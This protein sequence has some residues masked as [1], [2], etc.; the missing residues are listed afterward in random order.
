MADKVFNGRI[1]HKN[2]IEENWK[3]AIN[4]I[5]KKSELIIYNPD[6]THAQARVKVGD[7][8]TKV[9]DL[10]FTI[11][12]VK[13]VTTVNGKTGASIVL[14]GDDI[15]FSAG[16]SS[17]NTIKYNIDG[18]WSLAETAQT[19]AEDAQTTAE[20][21]Q[22]TAET[23]Q[24]TAETAQNTANNAMP[25]SPIVNPISSSEDTVTKWTEL[26]SGFYWV[27]Q[28]NVVQNQ[29]NTWGFICNIVFQLNGSHEC[30]QFWLSQPGGDAYTRGGNN[31]NWAQSWVRLMNKNNFS[32]DGSTLN[33]SI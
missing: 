27:T 29:P 10:P 22:T 18:A 24:T 8:V 16:D 4:F 25:K 2:D 30:Y 6:N 9:N 3:K 7:G 33:I 14:T 26:G 23:A 5:P 21:A 11:D 15:P 32:V 20:T 13:Q 28:N 1:I 17:E 31:N 19:T 12:D